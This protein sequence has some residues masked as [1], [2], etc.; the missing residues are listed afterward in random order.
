MEEAKCFEADGDTFHNPTSAGRKEADDNEETN[1]SAM[2][3]ISAWNCRQAER[4][5]GILVVGPGDSGDPQCYAHPSQVQ[6]EKLKVD[7]ETPTSFLQAA[8]VSR[9]R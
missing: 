8:C 4:A 1:I 7:K 9:W 2:G 3:H 5:D 6:E